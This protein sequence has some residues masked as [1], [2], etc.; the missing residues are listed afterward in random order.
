MSHYFTKQLK[1]GFGWIIVLAIIVV[2][3]YLLFI[4]KTT[5]TCFDGNK[6]Q[7]EENVDC[8][9]PCKSCNPVQSLSII[10]QIFIPTTANNY[11]LMAK[12]KNPNNDQGAEMINYEFNLYDGTDQLIGTR[13]GKTYIL[14]QETKYIVEQKFTTD[15]TIAR[16]EFKFNNISWIKL[17]QINDLELRI[18]NTE[19][20]ITEDASNLL[21][22]AIENRTSYD[23]DTIKV[24]GVLFDENKNTIAVGETSMNTVLRNESRGFEIFWPYPIPTEVKSFDVKVY[25]DVFENDNF[26]KTHGEPENIGQ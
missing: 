4:N 18:K 8:G 11:D 5:P 1:I 13:T 16:I 24:V 10:S 20:Q 25:T 12:I 2:G 14:P 3:I 6:N 9:G 22:G 21:V 15:K 23:L 17:S 7:G 26:I 19:Y